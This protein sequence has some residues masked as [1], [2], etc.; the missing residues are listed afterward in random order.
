MVSDGF[1]SRRS[2]TLPTM[3]AGH[4]YSSLTRR[5]SKRSH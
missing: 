5:W 3:G 1:R 2:A 4:A